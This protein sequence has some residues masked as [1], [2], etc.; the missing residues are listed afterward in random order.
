MGNMRVYGAILA[1]V[2]ILATIIVIPL[3]CDRKA[4]NQLVDW[5]QD[6]LHKHP[7]DTTNLT[8]PYMAHYLA[9]TDP[10]YLVDLYDNDP[11][12]IALL[13]PTTHEWITARRGRLVRTRIPLIDY[14]RL[15]AAFGQT[16]PMLLF[17]VGATCT[18]RRYVEW[19]A[20][21]E[22]ERRMTLTWKK[23]S[24]DTPPE[25]DD[26]EALAVRVAAWY[27]AAHDTGR[28]EIPSGGT[29][30]GV[31]DVD[32]KV[33]SAKRGTYMRLRE[34]HNRTLADGADLR[35]GPLLRLG[36]DL[37]ERVVSVSGVDAH[38]AD[39]TLYADENVG[40]FKEIEAGLVRK[41]GA[42][43]VLGLV[44]RAATASGRTIGV[45]ASQI[46]TSSPHVPSLDDL[47]TGPLYLWP[48]PLL[49]EPRGR[50]ESAPMADAA[51]LVGLSL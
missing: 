39:Y 9:E 11:D 26:T 37:T 7:L 13:R 22:R 50:F 2:A 40:L 23:I 31:L 12:A 19:R 28:P 44:H 30:V 4:T 41:G 21:E 48:S 25:T 47:W 1:L 29:F 5:T 8:S 38:W 33:G 24:T 20:A 36:E 34:S 49:L 27:R 45:C 18:A 3:V 42:K 15:A 10:Q 35:L 16:D 46:V 51:A 14:A 17:L 32:A 43:H 6:A